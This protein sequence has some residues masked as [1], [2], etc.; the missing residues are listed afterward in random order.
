MTASINSPTF[1]RSAPGQKLFLF[2]LVLFCNSFALAQ[3]PADSAAEVEVYRPLHRTPASLITTLAPL[4][5]DSAAFSTD[6]QQLV[7]RAA[8]STLKSVLKTITAIDIPLRH[9]KVQLSDQPR[10]GNAQV[11][12][13]QSR[14]FRNQTFRLTENQPLNLVQEKQ[15]QT[16]NGVSPWWIQVSEQTVQQEYLQLSVSSVGS[17][18]YLHITIRE[19]NNGQLTSIDRQITTELDQWVSL[20]QGKADENGPRTIGTRARQQQDLFL[21]VT[22]P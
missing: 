1:V 2:L 20:Y 8:P 5:G 7:T 19:L 21:K 11:Y 13:T 6:G 3:V 14:S 22:L 4:Y 16:V 18:L 17:T 15:A 10:S 12:S 9:F